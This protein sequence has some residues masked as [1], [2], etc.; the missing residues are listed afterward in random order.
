[1]RIALLLLTACASTTAPDLVPSS[2]ERLQVVSLPFGDDRLFLGLYDA[3]L[4]TPCFAANAQDGSLRC[5]P[6]A[7]W[8]GFLG[9]GL[10]STACEGG[11][12]L[13]RPADTCAAERPYLATP[14]SMPCQPPTYAVLALE[15]WEGSVSLSDGASCLDISLPEAR[16]PGLPMAPDRLAPLG[17]T[18]VL[19]DDGLGQRWFVSDDGLALPADLASED[20]ACTP[21][22]LADGRTVCLP[23]GSV[24][25]RPLDLF[26]DGTCREP[27]AILTECKDSHEVRYVKSG[28]RDVRLFHA[29]G[30]PRHADVAFDLARGRC[31]ALELDPL[32]VRA[33]VGLGA[34]V[35]ADEL[36]VL[37][38]DPITQDG[39]T[40]R[41]WR[42]PEGHRL[43]EAASPT[44]DGERCELIADGTHVWCLPGLTSAAQVA[45]ADAACTEPVSRAAGPHFVLDAEVECA[46][47]RLQ[48]VDEVWRR[49]DVPARGERYEIRSGRCLRNGF[50]S[51]DDAYL[52][53][54]PLEAVAKRLG[55]LADL[56]P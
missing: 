30:E 48:Q 9:N 24:A 16:L 42:D 10:L 32:A 35:G 51:G 2:G 52:E 31:N 18:D 5:I 8:S 22:T 50:F 44:V 37:T 53:A 23:D 3:E 33:L 34:E 56:E 29:S 15:P 45:Y 13:V 1:M 19:G 26:A 4:D 6:T 27:A 21:E 17:E 40:L 28:N 41:R 54:L 11:G 38:S 20:G 47:T 55:T 49:T 46:R 39:V 43:A 14:V 12:T 7:G 25:V 36:P